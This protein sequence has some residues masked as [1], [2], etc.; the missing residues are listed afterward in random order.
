MKASK[1]RTRLARPRTAGSV[2]P[3]TSGSGGTRRFSVAH[4]HAHAHLHAHAQAGARIR[5]PQSALP[6]RGR[7]RR[8]VKQEWE[9]GQEEEGEEHGEE[10]YRSTTVM[11]AAPPH[12][13]SSTKP[14]VYVPPL[15]TLASRDPMCEDDSLPRS[16]RSPRSSPPSSMEEAWQ[17]R[18]SVPASESDDW[19]RRSDVP[20]AV[21]QR[22]VRPASASRTLAG[23]TSPIKAR[24]QSA[25]VRV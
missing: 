13:A 24:P 17:R 3:T 11:A 15:R 1:T 18:P 16:P 23:V 6:S 9:G 10:E 21:A 14:P 4:A 5:R 7:D 8:V 22:S 25:T 19:E 20:A 12:A 2:R